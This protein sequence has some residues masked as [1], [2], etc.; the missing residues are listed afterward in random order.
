VI[1]EEQTGYLTGIIAGNC[2][3]TEIERS[4]KITYPTREEKPWVVDIV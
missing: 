2:D 3:A 4:L 1:I